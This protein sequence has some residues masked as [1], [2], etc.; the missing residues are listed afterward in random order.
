MTISGIHEIRKEFLDFFKSKNHLVVESYPLVPL[1]DKSLLLVN[2]GMAPLKPYFTGEKKAPNKRMASCQRCI[3]TGDIENV[4]VT[5]RHATYFEML[6][7]FSFGDYF[8]KEAIQWSWE[9]LT[10]VLKLDKEDL[11][12]SVYHKDLESKKIWIEE[13]GVREDRIVGLGKEDNFWEL[14]VGPCGPSSEIYVDRGEEYGC[15]EASCQPGCECDRFIEVWNLVFTQFDK[16]ESGEYLDLDEP[17]IDT[18]MGLERIAAVMQNADNIFEIREIKEL[19]NY[20]AEMAGKTYGES[21]DID[22]SLRIITDHTR[23]MTFLISDGVLPSNEGRGYVLRRLIRRAARHG[24]LLGLED[25]FLSIISNKF[26]DMWGPH[27]EELLERREKI[28]T[29]IDR[30]EEQFQETINQGLNIL[31]GYIEELKRENSKILSGEKA[32]KL[33]DTYG[34]PLDLTKEILEEDNYSV[35]EEGFIEHMEAQRERARSSRG[36]GLDI[37]WSSDDKR[38]RIDEDVDFKG[39]DLYKTQSKVVAL[40]VDGEERKSLSEGDKGILVLD[41]TPFYGESGGQV[42]D[43]GLIYNDKVKIEVIDTQK[44]KDDKIIHIIELLSGKIELGDQVTGEIDKLRRQDIMRNHTGT[45]LLH[46]ALKNHLGDH[47]SQAGSIVLPDRLRFDF[48]HYEKVDDETLDKIEKEINDIIYSG[49]EVESMEMSLEESKELGAVG[50]FEDQYGD[51]VRVI[52]IGDY[53]IELCGGTH[54]DNLNNIG[55]FKIISESSVASGTRRIEAI[56]GRYVYEYL[57]ERDSLI[58]SISK[59]LKTQEDNILDRV[60]EIQDLNAG[61]EKEIES[62]KAKAASSAG[63]EV[64]EKVRTVEGLNILTYNAGQ[65]DNDYLLKLSDQLREKLDSYVIVLAASAKDSV[66]FVASVS[67]DLVKKG[68]HAGNIIRE[69][70]KITKGGGGGRPNM[71]QAGGKDASKI[72]EALALV[73]KL[74]LEQLKN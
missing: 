23:A 11:W 19:L 6:G 27:Y 70:A 68:L 29:I 35:D 21:K 41:Q 2:A 55:I 24:K 65:V 20:V 37:G 30:E 33:Y 67:D 61:Y 36:K 74:A 69:V 4:G 22:K 10:E 26:I 71:A 8:K 64:L 56:T 40:T 25:S 52:K 73:D 54:I 5:D 45:H 15:K 18:G 34:F 32:F 12:I 57:Q 46:Q 51:S 9:F 28:K 63:D 59:E 3:R 7:N 42:G 48:T 17:N 13:V 14:E 60:R 72:G 43:K 31:D 38:I 50:L 49:M 1:N 39:Y 44:T 16:T 66:F 62:L 53:S 58:N 47:V